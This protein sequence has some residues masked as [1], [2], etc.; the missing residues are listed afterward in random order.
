MDEMDLDYDVQEIEGENFGKKPPKWVFIIVKSLGVIALFII[1][2][3]IL[4]QV[5]NLVAWIADINY[6]PSESEIDQ[7]QDI[8]MIFEV[9]RPFDVTIV[10]ER[11][12]ERNRMVKVI[13]PKVIL[14]YDAQN[15]ELPS[16]INT[17]EP[18]IERIIRESLS[19]Q[20]IDD[21]INSKTREKIVEN[22]LLTNL[23]AYLVG[24]EIPSTETTGHKVKKGTRVEVKN[25]AFEDYNYGIEKNYIKIKNLN[26]LNEGWIPLDT[27]EVEK[28][29]LK[30][31]YLFIVNTSKVLDEID[32]AIN[33]EKKRQESSDIIER[34]DYVVLLDLFFSGESEDVN[35]NYVKVKNEKTNLMGWIPLDAIEN[36]EKLLIEEIYEVKK[37]TEIYKTDKLGG[38]VSSG[39]I[40]VYFP[41]GFKILPIQ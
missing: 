29:D 27:V 22:D 9:A 8:P 2:L 6:V 16:I 24:V 28:K 39:I 4:F 13:V 18:N 32:V 35:N 30:G 20:K 15:S 36:P 38:F 23:N 7:P 41:K 12:N 40:E 11:D 14:A 37:E 10:E 33:N 5:R 17:K 31:R 3:V 19:S 1:G 25:T 34:G 21:L 26:T